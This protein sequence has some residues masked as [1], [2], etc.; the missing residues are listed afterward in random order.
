MAI[1]DKYSYIIYNTNNTEYITT[2]PYTPLW[3]FVPT[4][5]RT[6]PRTHLYSRIYSPIRPCI[7]PTTTAYSPMREGSAPRITATHT[8][9]KAL[10]FLGFHAINELYLSKIPI[11]VP[12]PQ[13]GIL[14]LLFIGIINNTYSIYLYITF[15]QYRYNYHRYFS[16]NARI[17]G[18]GGAPGY[19]YTGVKRV[20]HTRLGRNKSRYKIFPGS[21]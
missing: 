13:R 18:G 6:Y 7:Y 17:S 9:P 4:Y 2:S 8:R 14:Y 20:P 10:N 11:I 3:A 21:K 5:P 1:M 12:M 16:C 19:E 15:I